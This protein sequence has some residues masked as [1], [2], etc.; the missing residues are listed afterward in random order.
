[1]NLK[2]EIRVD[3]VAD[4]ERALRALPEA[5]SGPALADALAYGA[6]PVRAE[7][8]RLAPRR[9]GQLAEEIVTVAEV[10]GR[11][12]ASARTGPSREAFHGLFQEIGTAHHAAQPFLRPAF[13]AMQAEVQRRT[14]ERLGENLE[15]VGRGA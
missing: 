13:D 2:V 12:R 11:D 10:T 9:T 1:M 4:V 7:A 6:E 8:S 14:A 3:G 5:T 15:R